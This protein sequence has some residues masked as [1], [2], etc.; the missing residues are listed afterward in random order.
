MNEFLKNQCEVEFFDYIE[1]NFGPFVDLSQDEIILILEQEPA[2]ELDID[3][4]AQQLF[5]YVNGN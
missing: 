1:E 2:L 4:L 3:L 5:N